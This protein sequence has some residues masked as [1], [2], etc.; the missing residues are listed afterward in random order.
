MRGDLQRGLNYWAVVDTRY[1]TIVLTTNNRAISE[2]WQRCVNACQ[3]N[4]PYDILWHDWKK[5][6]I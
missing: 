1:N 3:H 5:A 2:Q 6:T 4:R